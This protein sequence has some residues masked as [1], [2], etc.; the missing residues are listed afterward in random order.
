M[1]FLQDMKIKKTVKSENVKA[2]NNFSK[3]IDETLNELEDNHRGFN[4]KPAFKITFK[5][6]SAMIVLVLLILPNIARNTRSWQY[7]KSYYYKKIF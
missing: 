4:K 5:Y 2:P 1:K 7:S 6:A 3:M